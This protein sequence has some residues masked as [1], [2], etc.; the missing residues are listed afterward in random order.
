MTWL[1]QNTYTGLKK[2]FKNSDGIKVPFSH[3][4]DCKSISHPFEYEVVLI[5]WF[6]GNGIEILKP[7]LPSYAF[8]Q[9][10]KN[11]VRTVFFFPCA[12]SSNKNS[13]SLTAFCVIFF[14]RKFLNFHTGHD[15]VL[16]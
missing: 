6:Y 11:F 3:S 4:D 16:W 13:C 9:I 10:S 5:F 2:D 12:G 1:V 14:F 8:F 15:V 7:K